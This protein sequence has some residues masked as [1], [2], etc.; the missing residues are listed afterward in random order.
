MGYVHGPLYTLNGTA[1][2]NLAATWY[3]D[4]VK[5]GKIN[6]VNNNPGAFYLVIWAK[7]A[8]STMRPVPMVFNSHLN[9]SA[10][11]DEIK[12]SVYPNPVKSNTQ[13]QLQLL[14]SRHV[15][16]EVYSQVGVLE[17][18]LDKHTLPA[19]FSNIS[20]DLS[21]L[22]AGLHLLKLYADDKVYGKIIY[23]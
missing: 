20:L 7:P 13:L 10:I 1:Q 12:W 9:A 15:K 2:K 22:N 19:G 16:I 23:K 18:S 17:L 4:G 3:Y 5:G 8:G 14:Q 21:S 11:K 6:K